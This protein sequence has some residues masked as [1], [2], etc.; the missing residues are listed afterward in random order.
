M[1]LRR[2][3]LVAV[4]TFGLIALPG[5]ASSA[6]A[7]PASTRAAKVSAKAE[8]YPTRIAF[9]QFDRSRVYGTDTVVRGQVLT[10]AGGGGSLV[11]T[12]SLERRFQGSTTWVKVGE[13]TTTNPSFPRFTFT[14]RTVA[15]AFYRVRYAGGTVL[16]AD[17]APSVNDTKVTAIRKITTNVRSRQLVVY[18]K[19]TPS[20]TG[21]RMVVERATCAGCKFKPLRTIKVTADSRYRTTL[22]APARGKWWWRLSTRADRKFVVSRT[23]TIVTRQVPG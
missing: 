8:P 19:V 13:A 20:Y 16:G 2:L 22:T 15:N 17:F 5:I 6:S 23:A 12:V 11:V 18:G 7:D 1:S 14:L 4:T 21:K 9:M 3:L 10:D